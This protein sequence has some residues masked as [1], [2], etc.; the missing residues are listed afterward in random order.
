M[1]TRKVQIWKVENEYH[2]VPYKN[3]EAQAYVPVWLWEGYLEHR[4]K[5]RDIKEAINSYFNH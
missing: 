3:A 2:R 1:D 5:L 4:T